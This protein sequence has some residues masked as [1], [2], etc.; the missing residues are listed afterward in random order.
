MGS[1]R[2]SGAVISDSRFYV[3]RRISVAG[4]IL[5]ELSPASQTYDSSDSTAGIKSTSH[6]RR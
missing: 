1:E 5:R 2:P 3:W 4:R 6:L